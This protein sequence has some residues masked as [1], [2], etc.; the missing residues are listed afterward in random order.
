MRLRRRLRKLSLPT[1]LR[2]ELTLGPPR[3]EAG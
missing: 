3:S 2:C 1:I